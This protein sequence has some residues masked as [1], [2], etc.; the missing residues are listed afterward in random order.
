VCLC[1][2]LSSEFF[3]EIKSVA[4]ACAME[5]KK[6][7]KDVAIIYNISFI[8]IILQYCNHVHLI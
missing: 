3:I 1:V 6:I 5:T 7:D 8:L 2:D 4:V